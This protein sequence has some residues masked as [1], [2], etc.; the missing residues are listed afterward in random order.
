MIST[1]YEMKIDLK[2][3]K[4]RFD[5]EVK[6]L[7][8]YIDFNEHKLTERKNNLNKLLGED[9]IGNPS[10]KD[11]LTDLYQHD[12]IKLPTYFYHSTVISIF[13]L[14]EFTLNEICDKVTE[15]TEIP[16]HSKDLAGKNIIGGARLFLS[17]LGN[18]S[19]KKV[20]VEWLELTKIQKIRNY[21]V[22]QNARINSNNKEGI[23][24]IKGIK[25]IHFDIRTG[26]FRIENVNLLT[27]TLNLTHDFIV[28][29]F[30]EV[31]NEEFNKYKINNRSDG[32]FF[33][34]SEFDSGM[35]YGGSDDLPF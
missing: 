11:S 22:H 13:S 8:E 29:L 24:F 4:Y 26:Y 31:E 27:R 35:S 25:E 19:F 5:E 30:A 15:D 23:D 17:K 16:I 18:I 34:V 20:E 1:C 12:S 6:Y 14:S 21:I 9:I 3:I 10:L 32:F 28:K 33:D 2:E 7:R